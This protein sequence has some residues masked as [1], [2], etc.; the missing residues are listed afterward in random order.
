M[1]KIID[2]HIRC[3]CNQPGIQTDLVNY[4]VPETGNKLILWPDQYSFKLQARAL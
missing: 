1:N 4:K 3:N 2:H